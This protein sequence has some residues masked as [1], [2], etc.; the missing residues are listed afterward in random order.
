MLKGQSVTTYLMTMREYKNQ[1]EKMGQIITKSIHTATILRNI[2]ESW[3][4]M[5]Q[6][7]KMIT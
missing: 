6:T 1:L 7:I 3:Q 4:P 5:V 2:P